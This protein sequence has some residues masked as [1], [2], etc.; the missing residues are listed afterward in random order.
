MVPWGFSFVLGCAEDRVVTIQEFTARDRLSLTD[1]NKS[2][3][4]PVLL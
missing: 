3:R 2:A 4:K 1:E